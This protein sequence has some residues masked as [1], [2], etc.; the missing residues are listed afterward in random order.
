MHWLYTQPRSLTRAL[1]CVTLTSLVRIRLFYSV[2]IPTISRCH[3]ILQN[4]GACACSV[5]QAFLSPPPWRPGDEARLHH[6]LLLVCDYWWLVVVTTST[7][8]MWSC[9]TTKLWSSFECMILAVK[10]SLLAETEWECEHNKL[11][12]AWSYRIRPS[13]SDVD[14]GAKVVR[15]TCRGRGQR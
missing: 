12:S 6:A 9:I 2:S 13:W 15:D 7:D 4:D 14:R 11:F 8:W 10:L 1:S 3:R 5:Y